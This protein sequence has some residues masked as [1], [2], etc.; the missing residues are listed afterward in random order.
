MN[1]SRGKMTLSRGK[2]LVDFSPWTRL[3]PQVW[4]NPRLCIQAKVCGGLKSFLET[5]RLPERVEEVAVWDKT[6]MPWE[7]LWSAG[8]ESS[9]KR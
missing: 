7:G 2:I 5:E 1:L 9:G 6:G 4:Y 8:V 3:N